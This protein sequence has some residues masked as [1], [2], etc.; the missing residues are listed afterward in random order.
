MFIKSKS[1]YSNSGEQHASG[2]F[3]IL[4]QSKNAPIGNNLRAIVRHCSMTQFGQFMM[5]IVR[6]KGKSITVSGAYGSDGLPLTVNENI[7]QAGIPLPDHL[8]QAWAH[9]NGWN[10]S[11]SETS[12]MKQWA[13]DNLKQLK[14]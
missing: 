3:L 9:G 10:S 4:M 11:G 1:G 13:L 6:I 7:Y 14:G 12:L 5:G 2:L 8:Y